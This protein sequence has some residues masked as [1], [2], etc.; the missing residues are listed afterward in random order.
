MQKLNLPRYEWAEFFLNLAAVYRNR[1]V[2]IKQYVDNDLNTSKFKEITLRDIVL[3]ENGD[4]QVRIYASDRS[5]HDVSYVIF[6]PQ[7]VEFQK[8]SGNRITTVKITNTDGLMTT[9]EF[10]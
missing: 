7:I 1:R 2:A 10:R 4:S 5:N 3:M 9:F 6:Q 8:Q